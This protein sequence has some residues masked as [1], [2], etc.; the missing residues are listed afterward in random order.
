MAYKFFE[1]A[2]EGEYE[3]NL[4]VLAEFLKNEMQSDTPDV[5]GFARMA[6]RIEG[7]THTELKVIVLI[8]ASLS[9]NAV[10]TE[11][12]TQT[13]RPFVSAHSLR[14][15]A[16]VAHD[17]RADLDQLCR[18]RQPIDALFPQSHDL[19]RDNK[20][21]DNFFCLCSRYRGCLELE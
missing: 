17:L 18:Y 20:K 8:N 11:A 14:N 3:H 2:K 21:A 5:S 1:A 19:D 6:R 7:L 16:A 4:R 12:T 10:S 9:A 13:E 15:I